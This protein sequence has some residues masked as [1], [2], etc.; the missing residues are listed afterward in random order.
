MN[1]T[2]KFAN[3]KDFTARRPLLMAILNATPDSFSDGGE[4]ESKSNLNKRIQEVIAE[5]ADIIDV[6]GESTRPGFETV[7]ESTEIERVV[8]VIKALRNISKTMPISI[9]TQKAHVA[10]AAIE[11]GA[12]FINDISSLSDP[13][14]SKVANEYNC[15]VILMRSAALSDNL[16]SDCKDQFEQ[17]VKNAESRDIDKNQLILDP[18]LGFGDLKTKNFSVL[19][20]SDLKANLELIHSIPDYSLGFPVLIGGSRKRFIGEMM[21]EPDPKKRVSGSV[22]IAVSAAKA[23]ASI[24][25]VHDVKETLEGLKQAGLRA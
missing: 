16:I 20:G 1:L 18:G 2:L 21:N 9:D 14:M 3:N 7:D 4:L 22:E 11:A 19:P 5:G 24:L 25:R 8:P 10:K 17:I 15:S 12:D 13:E 6:G 23:G